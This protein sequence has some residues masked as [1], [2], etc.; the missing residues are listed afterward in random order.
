MLGALV[1]LGSCAVMYAA[2]GEPG[3][4]ISGLKPGATR[5]QVEAVVGSPVNQWSTSQGVRYRLYKYYGGRRPDAADAAALLFLDIGSL[6]LNE[7]FLGLE[8]KT[9]K[10]WG[11][12]RKRYPLMAV[13]YDMQDIVIGVFPEVDQFTALP[14]DGR[15][16]SSAIP[17][18]TPT[19]EK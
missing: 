8:D 1:G 10:N 14:P 2:S 7:L 15:A 5:E 17:A 18:S 6:G 16:P 19:P 12:T 11:E 9:M 4:D 13:A 3:L